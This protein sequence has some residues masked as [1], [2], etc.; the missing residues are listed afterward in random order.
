V[1]ALEAEERG[2]TTKGR[3]IIRVVP[4]EEGAEPE[5]QQSTGPHK[6]TLQDAQGTCVYG[7]ELTNV[8][9]IGLSMSIGTKL[10]LRDIVVARGLLLLEPKNVTVL[11]GKIEELHKKWKEGRKEVLKAAAG[12]SNG[13]IR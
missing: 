13:G 1:E 9:G 2:E 8:N 12:L 4:G 10:V 7:M 3:E 5:V 11:G 6:L